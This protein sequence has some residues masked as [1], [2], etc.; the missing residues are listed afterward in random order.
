VKVALNVCRV[1]VPNLVGF[2]V[3]ITLIAP[4]MKTLVQEKYDER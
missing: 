1:V 3:R 2:V 4:L